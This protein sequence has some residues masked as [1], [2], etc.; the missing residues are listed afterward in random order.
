M[1]GRGVFAV[2]LQLA[3]MCDA[4]VLMVGSTRSAPSRRQ[5]PAA[6]TA[7]AGADGGQDGDTASRGLPPL[8]KRR[9]S[10]GQPA[11]RPPERGSVLR[12]LRPGSG[13]H[14]QPDKQAGT[15]RAEGGGRMTDG[16]GREGP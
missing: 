4:G 10:T 12:M 5:G 8:P 2:T 14:R 3:R 11:A 1:L 7:Q 6:A 15:R 16:E 9:R 13:A